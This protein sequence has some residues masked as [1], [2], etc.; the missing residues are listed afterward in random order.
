MPDGMGL[1]RLVRLA[2]RRA[3]VRQQA[4][5]DLGVVPSRLQ[6]RAD[7]ALVAGHQVEQHGRP[8]QGGEPAAADVVDRL[9]DGRLLARGGPGSS[10]GPLGVADQLVGSAAERP[11]GRVV[12]AFSRGADRGRPSTAA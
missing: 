11:D 8:D 2:D 3:E 5:R 7:H 6:A 10:P 4:A 12:G 1:G 9:P